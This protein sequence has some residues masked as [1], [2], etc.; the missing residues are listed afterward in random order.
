ML[1]LKSQCPHRL[2]L[3]NCFYFACVLSSFI[4]ALWSCTVSIIGL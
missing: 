3:N 1:F 2:F 4:P